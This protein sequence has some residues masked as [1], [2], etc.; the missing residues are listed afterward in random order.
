MAGGEFNEADLFFEKKNLKLGVYPMNEGIGY[1]LN[2]NGYNKASIIS[3]IP[4]TESAHNDFTDRTIYNPSSVFQRKE[5]EEFTVILPEGLLRF[6]TNQLK[7]GGP[8]QF[9]MVK[10]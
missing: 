1:H 3:I 7:M 5:K 2:H 8:V 6:N 9:E 4:N 10:K